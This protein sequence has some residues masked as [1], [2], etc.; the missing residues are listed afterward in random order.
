MP[1]RRSLLA[2]PIFAALSSRL[3]AAPAAKPAPVWSLA[4]SPDGALLAS[5]TYKHIDLWDLSTRTARR[6]EGHA[7]A[8]RCLAWSSDGTRLAGGGGKPGE[9]G[10]VKVWTLAGGGPVTLLE[11]KDLVEGLAFLPS[12][13]TLVSAGMDDRALVVPVDTGK[14]SHALMD[15]TNRVVAVAVSPSGK[16]L[17]TGS[18]DTTVK[19]WS[20]AD[21]KP[22]A[23]LDRNGG[24]VHA[25]AFLPAGDLL[26]VGGEDG[27]VR[28]YRLRETRSGGLAGVSG[29]IARTFNGNRTPVLT[30]AAASK[31]NLLA[32]GGADRTV[33]VFDANGGRKYVLNECPDAVYALAFSPDGLTLAAGCRD[34]KVRLWSMAD[35]K[36]LLE[37]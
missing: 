14:S 6:L 24:P 16:Y 36:L 23:N 37:L 26:L 7:G 15:H 19:I 30:V 20:A 33:S 17:A 31:G 25:L 1:S 32:W 10:E 34:G 35:G 11:H 27:N 21:Y 3:H 2:T 28:I 29:E 9:L 4:Y 12:A 22:L 18:L 8:V 13:A 5:G